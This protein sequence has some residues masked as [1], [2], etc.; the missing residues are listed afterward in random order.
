ME[1]AV[2]YAKEAYTAEQ[3]SV[4]CAGREFSPSLTALSS[5]RIVYVGAVVVAA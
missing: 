3:M 4:K 2:C 1:Y 5:I